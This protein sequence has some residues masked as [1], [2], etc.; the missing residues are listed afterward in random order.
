MANE[1]GY[2]ITRTMEIEENFTGSWQLYSKPLLRFF[3]KY[4]AGISVSKHHFPHTA[5]W[6]GNHKKFEDLISCKAGKLLVHPWSNSRKSTDIILQK[7]GRS[8]QGLIF[9]KQHSWRRVSIETIQNCFAYCS[10]EHSELKMLKKANS[11]N[12]IILE[13]HHIRNYEVFMCWQ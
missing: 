6:H 10:F 5:N 4:P 9:Y 8:M 1:L 2:G 7:L 11:E 13:M 3:E 12:D